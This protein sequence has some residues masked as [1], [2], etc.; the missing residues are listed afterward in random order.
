MNLLS[1][2]LAHTPHKNHI[3]CLYGDSF[4]VN[5]QHI[6]YY[7][8]ILVKSGES[9]GKM[10]LTFKLVDQVGLCCLLQC[11]EGTRL[12]PEFLTNIVCD[13]TDELLKW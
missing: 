13:F 2:S 1:K 10:E 5:H 12:E 3:L 8:N 7:S 9:I 4:G 6:R 11:L